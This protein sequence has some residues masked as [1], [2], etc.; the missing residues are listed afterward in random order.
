MTTHPS[1]RQF[2]A[3]VRSLLDHPTPGEDMKISTTIFGSEERKKKQPS[4]PKSLPPGEEIDSHWSEL[5]KKVT[6][7]PTDDG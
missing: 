5:E 2:P 4:L 7:N 1:Y 3:S 6:G